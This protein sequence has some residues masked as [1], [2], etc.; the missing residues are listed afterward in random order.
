MKGEPA[1]RTDKDGILS[2][3]TDSATYEHF[4]RDEQMAKLVLFRKPR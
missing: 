2:T 4:A 3:I 1:L